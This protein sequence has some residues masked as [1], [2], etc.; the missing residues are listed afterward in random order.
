MGTPVKLLQVDYDAAA[1]I[2]DG[3]LSLSQLSLRM[4]SV[5]AAELRAHTLDAEARAVEA[6]AETSVIH[7]LH[8]QLEALRLEL[9]AFT[10]AVALL[11]SR[12]GG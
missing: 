7:E 5:I 4:R 2:L 8:R 1:A 9:N 3:N 10:D 6:R 12:I 11:R